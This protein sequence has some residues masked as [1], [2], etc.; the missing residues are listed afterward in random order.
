[1]TI[2][3]KEPLIVLMGFRCK[4]LLCRFAMIFQ[5]LM[6]LVRILYGNAGKCAEGCYHFFSA[7]RKIK[8]AVVRMIQAEDL[9]QLYVILFQHLRRIAV[10]IAAKMRGF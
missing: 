5:A 2:I 8:E 4:H 9:L 10:K 7:L 1:M 3:K 6:H